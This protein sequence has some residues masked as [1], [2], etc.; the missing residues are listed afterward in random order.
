MKARIEDIRL[1]RSSTGAGYLLCKQVLEES[2]GNIDAAA[3]RLVSIGV[4]MIDNSDVRRKNGLVC[5]YVHPGNRMGAFVEVACDTDFTAKTDEF[6]RFANELA[7][8]IAAMRPKYLSRDDVP[9]ERVT[10]EIDFRTG[11]LTSEGCPPECLDNA[12]S[13]EMEQWFSETCLLE[14]PSI[15]D[16]S[17]TVQELL[18]DIIMKTHERCGIERFDRW[19][20]GDRLQDVPPE[21][22][23]D[24]GDIGGTR[25]FAAVS[26]A[27]LSLMLG[28]AVAAIVL[29]MIL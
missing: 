24:C 26:F 13:S 15:R 19:E 17:K 2:G 9:F 21:E 4:K 12:L 23:E 11:R 16:G 20:V 27:I 6:K 7:M 1:L 28:F 25:K 3:K 18:G 29:L 10:A 5:S 14:Q 8:Q 22:R